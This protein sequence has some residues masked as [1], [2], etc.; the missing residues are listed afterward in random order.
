MARKIT[1]GTKDVTDLITKP[2]WYERLCEEVVVQ[3]GCGDVKYLNKLVNFKSDKTIK[4][5]NFTPEEVQN[6][7]KSIYIETLKDLKMPVSLLA[8]EVVEMKVAME[9][10]R[11]VEMQRMDESRGDDD[12]L[13]PLMLK[14]HSSM[15]EMM[16]EL[17]KYTL[18]TKK[19]IT[20]KHSFN[21]EEDGIIDGNWGKK[22]VIDVTP[23]EEE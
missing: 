12:I 18:K 8:K 22:E 11:M 16:K 17:N 1:K 14:M 13:S 5:L 6:H 21:D 9:K 10:Q 20:V 4:E 3:E 23:V 19:E 7:L 15:V 2:D